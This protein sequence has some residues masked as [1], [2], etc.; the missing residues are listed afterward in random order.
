MITELTRGALRALVDTQGGELVSLRDGTGTEYIWSGDPAFWSGRNPILFPI[1]GALKDGAVRIRGR[2]CEMAQHGFARRRA[3]ALAE[4]G[5]DSVVFQLTEDA[6]T[7]AQYPC[8]FRLRVTHALTDRGFRTQFAVTNTGNEELPFCIGGHTAYCC[9][10]HEGERFEEYRLVFDQPEDA[11]T[12]LV[13]KNGLSHEGRETMLRGSD[14]IELRHE[15]FD[16]LDTLIFQGL[17]SKGVKL[18]HRDT[19]RG[20]RVDF[21]E[22]PMVAFWTMPHKNAPYLCIEP[23]QGCAAFDNDTGEFLDKPW[24]VVL[25]PGKTWTAG[26]TMA[27]V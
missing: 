10:I 24:R 3:F 22:F 5:E 18:I 14:T 15:I 8:P 2:T 27:L 7:L 4:R 13:T 9:P 21:S 19:G 25:G 11:D 6:D 1:V 16:R 12:I 23:W 26:Y 17:R 20:L